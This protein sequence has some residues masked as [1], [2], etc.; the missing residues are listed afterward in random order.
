M[1]TDDQLQTIEQRLYVITHP[2]DPAE[3]VHY[4]ALDFA[5]HAAGDVDALLAEVR[6][7]KVR[8]T[9]FLRWMNGVRIFVKYLI[10]ELKERHLLRELGIIEKLH[11]NYLKL[12]DFLH[13][14]P[15][16]EWTRDEAIAAYRSE[17][18]GV[19]TLAHI[20]DTDMVDARMQALVIDK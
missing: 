15:L 13:E 11:E 18:I 12:S 17:E 9:R 16:W 3:I 20:L 7:L 6:R 5:Q 8:E 19:S 2:D 1:M 14:R 4:A 10:G